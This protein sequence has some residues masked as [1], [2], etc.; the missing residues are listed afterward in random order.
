MSDLAKKFVD[1]LENLKQR[2]RGAMATLRHS[3]AFEPGGYP[4]AYPY[5]ER[6]VGTERHARDPWRLALYVVAGLYAR[7]PLQ[8]GQ[9][10]AA[11]LG[12]LLRKRES[13]ALEQRFVALLGADAENLHNYL[14][15]AISLLAADDVGCDFVGLL[16]DL[17]RWL[18]PFLDPERRDLVRQRWARDFY[19]AATVAIDAEEPAN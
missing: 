7:H 18:D 5:V 16:D 10:F 2:N 3:L 12:E 8:R 19:Q 14:R 6:F 9:S 1:H 17:R 11:S 15:Q 4:P 13:S